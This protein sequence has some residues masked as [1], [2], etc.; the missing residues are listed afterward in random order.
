MM[1]YLLKMGMFNY[2]SLPEGNLFLRFNNL[3]QAHQP[4]QS[5]VS[6]PQ[7]VPAY[8]RESMPSVS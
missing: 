7:P 4:S 8:A 3:I 1:V 6:S 2:V 5:A